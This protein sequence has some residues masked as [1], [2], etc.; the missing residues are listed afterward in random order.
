MNTAANIQPEANQSPLTS[1]EVYDRLVDPLI[2]QIRE[3]CKEHNLPAIMAIAL[4]EP[5]PEKD[6]FEVML[7]KTFM[8]EHTPDSFR[9]AAVMVEKNI[10]SPIELFGKILTETRKDASETN[11]A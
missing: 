8:G 9:M 4:P 11:E 5:D 6:S 2:D 3:L 7:A 1:R 10:S